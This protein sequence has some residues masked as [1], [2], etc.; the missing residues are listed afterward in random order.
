M[1]LV[2]LSLAFLAGIYVGSAR[3]IDQR[4]VLIAGLLSLLVAAIW[5]RQPR[6]RLAALCLFLLAAG[7]LRF[8]SAMPPSDYGSIALHVGPRAVEVGG[9]V[10]AEPDVRDTDTRLT[11]DTYHIGSGQDSYPVTGAIQVYVPHYATYRYGDDL[12]LK[13]VLEDPPL[14]DSFSYKQY[15]ERQGI[16]GAMYRPAIDVV[17]QN[18]GNHLLAALYSLKGRLQQA[19]YAYLPEP[20]V[21][22][23]QGVLLGTK[24]VISDELKNDLTQTGLTHVVVVSGYNL[25]VVATLLQRLTEKRLRKNLALLVALGGVVVYTLMTGATPPVVRAAIMVSMTLLAHAAGR[26]ADA[27][28]SLLFTAALLAGFDPQILWDISFQLSFMAT[29][30]LVLLSPPLERVMA[31]LPLGIGTILATTFAAQVMT[32]PIIALNFQRISLISP[33]ANLLVQPAIPAVML[34]GAI[35]AIAGMT[36]S[37]AV[38]LFGWGTWLFASYIVQVMHVL[39]G[40]PQAAADLPLLEPQTQRIALAVYFAIVALFLLVG[41]RSGRANLAA[42][43]YQAGATVVRPRAGV[44][45]AIVA[46]LALIVWL[47]VL[48]ILRS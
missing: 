22:L 29:L 42:A 28:T 33:L 47:G 40:L 27:L 31:F 6:V 23:V 21:G 18:Q 36:G 19:L 34:L 20:Q 26:D 2:Y 8:E 43:R 35:V 41:T 14:S 45:I 38:R 25:V 11:I 3:H 12:L 13:G 1:T 7:M 32:L 16:F 10:A 44:V 30:G 17:G 48:V 15:L 9:I 4:Y 46:A 24:A 5:R 39:G 37:A